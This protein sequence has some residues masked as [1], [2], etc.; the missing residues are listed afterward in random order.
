VIVGANPSPLRR[1]PLFVDL[2]EAELAELSTSLHRRR[3]PKGQF[4]FNQ[5][6][7]GASMC[8]IVAGRVQISVAS[9]EGKE[10]VLNQ[11]GPG[12]VVG[13]MALLDGEPRS[14]DAICQEAC[15]LLVLQREDFVRFLE[16]HPRVA[17][18]LLE[19]VSRKLR[20]TSRQAQDVAFL[21][22]PA[23]IARVLLE[24]SEAVDEPRTIPRRV[25]QTE[26]AGLIGATRE[27][28]NKWLG[29]YE[30]QGLIRREKGTLHVLKPAVL[31][32]RI[33]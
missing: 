10:L 16:A 7:P 1:V 8:L 23:R 11:L 25:T 5:G 22:V 29:Y 24:L 2:D 19:V 4:I 12:D 15:E 30:R 14:A 33:V 6:D 28:V 13:E 27:S 18:R 32:R 31:R 3:H 26:L 20:H 9:P 17:L 21:D